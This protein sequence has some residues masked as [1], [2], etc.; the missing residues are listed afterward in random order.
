[1]GAQELSHEEAALVCGV[2]AGTM[3]ARLS[4][5]RVALAEAA[6]RAERVE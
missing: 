5:A 6:A 3:K 4:R 1:M 2:P